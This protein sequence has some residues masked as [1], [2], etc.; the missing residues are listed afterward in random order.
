MLVTV[1]LRERNRSNGISGYFARVI[2]IGSPI[3]A[4]TPRPRAT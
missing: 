1:K 3:V 2:Q 4:T